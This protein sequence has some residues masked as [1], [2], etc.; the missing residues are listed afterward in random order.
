MK[1]QSET[2][3]FAAF[4][5]TLQNLFATT[6]FAIKIEECAEALEL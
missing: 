3:N 2:V 1:T 4:V 5:D 6:F